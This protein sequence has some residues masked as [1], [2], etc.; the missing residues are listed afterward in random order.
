MKVVKTFSDVF[1]FACVFFDFSGNMWNKIKTMQKYS[2]CRI[3]K[4]YMELG[5]VFLKQRKTFD[6]S[7][8]RNSH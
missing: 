1:R 8:D 5:T 6:F 3:T 7:F 2:V 4:K